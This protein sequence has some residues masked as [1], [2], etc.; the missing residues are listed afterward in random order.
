MGEGDA[1]ITIHTLCDALKHLHADKIV[2]RDLKPENILYASPDD[3]SP[4]KVADFGLARQLTGS[5]MMKT[6]CHS[7]IC[8]ARDFEKSRVRVG[9]RRRL[10]GRSRS[11]HPSVRI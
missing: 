5:E 1:A 10:V 11:V 4:I 8:R 6:A 2:H 3:D 9:C 7:W